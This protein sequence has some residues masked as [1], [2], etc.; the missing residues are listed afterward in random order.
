M[1]DCLLPSPD[2]DTRVTQVEKRKHQRVAIARPLPA[3][4]AVS[5]DGQRLP[6][7]WVKDVSRFGVNVVVDQVIPERTR[8]T[9]EYADENLRLDVYG[10]VAWRSQGGS[11]GQENSGRE[12]HVVGIELFS[13]TLLTAMLGAS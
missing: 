11:G 5:F 2:E 7:A 6:V 1:I 12:H 3:T 9:V 8:V 4:L 13:P 10:M